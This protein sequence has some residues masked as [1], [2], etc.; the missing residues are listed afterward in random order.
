MVIAPADP[1]HAPPLG[2]VF[3][4]SDNH[5]SGLTIHG[6]TSQL[7]VISPGAIGNSFIGGNFIGT[8]AGGTAAAG[9]TNGIS[10]IG[11][12][13]RIVGNVISGRAGVLLEKAGIRTDI[14]P[15]MLIVGRGG[16]MS[17]LDIPRLL[18][19]LQTRVGEIDLQIALKK[20]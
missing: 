14:A 19:P 12:G 2:L 11:D 16:L 17:S 8:N 18:V 1:A 10:V 5:I 4:S 3:R 20:G 15:P 7:S 6:F 13:N 9:G